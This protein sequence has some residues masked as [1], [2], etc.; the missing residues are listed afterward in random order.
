MA[1][2]AEHV[3]LR[4]RYVQLKIDYW[5]AVQ[6]ADDASVE[7]LSNEA[8]ALAGELKRTKKL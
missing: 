8:F 2:E 5:R 3:A 7:Q 4:A 6:A 1:A